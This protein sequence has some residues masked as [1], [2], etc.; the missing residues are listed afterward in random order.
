MEKGLTYFWIPKMHLGNTEK[1][2]AWSNRTGWMD[3]FMIQAK[4]KVIKE[5]KGKQNCKKDNNDNLINS[6]NL[7]HLLILLTHF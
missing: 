4:T 5:K 7:P 1:K 6:N 2:P 3:Y